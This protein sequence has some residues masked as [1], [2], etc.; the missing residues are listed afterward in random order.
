MTGR[1]P[2]PNRPQVLQE[3]Y[4]LS[5]TPDEIAADNGMSVRLVYLIAEQADIDMDLRRE[6]VRMVKKR[7][8]L[9]DEIIKKKQLFED[10][11]YFP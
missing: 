8:S 9:R 10:N 5:R 6:I 7:E 2:H 1:P 11:S 3:L 4:N